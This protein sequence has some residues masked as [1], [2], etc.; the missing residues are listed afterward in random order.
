MKDDPSWSS[1]ALL[2]SQY[3]ALFLANPYL[4]YIDLS[5]TGLTNSGIFY[6]LLELS[7][8]EPLPSHCGL[9]CLKQLVLG[10]PFKRSGTASCREPFMKTAISPLQEVYLQCPALELI[11]LVHPRAPALSDTEEVY[12]ICHRLWMSLDD[13]HR[14][15]NSHYQG[16]QCSVLRTRCAIFIALPSPCSHPR[17]PPNAQSMQEWNERSSAYTQAQSE[18]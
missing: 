18:V 3:T 8:C 12:S 4:Q 11:C 9:Q 17:A 16:M 13:D 5:Y 7:Y 15:A 1:G 14:V 6:L 2:A 10:P